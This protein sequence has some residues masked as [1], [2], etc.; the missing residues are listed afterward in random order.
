MP[1]ALQ[2][3]CPPRTLHH[4]A[5]QIS[6]TEAIILKTNLLIQES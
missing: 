4:G 1:L 6:N 2:R 3:G 5:W